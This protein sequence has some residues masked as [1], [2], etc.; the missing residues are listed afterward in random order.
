MFL[1]TL[2]KNEMH[3]A[4]AEILE[5]D[6]QV[7]KNFIVKNADEIVAYHYDKYSIEKMNLDALVNNN[8]SKRIDSLI[9]NHIHLESAKKVYGRKVY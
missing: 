9:V 2:G 6:V 3:E 5:T 7:I 8:N 1:N 4:V